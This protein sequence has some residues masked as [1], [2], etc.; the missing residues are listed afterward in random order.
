[1]NPKQKQSNKPKVKWFEYENKPVE[2][3]PCFKNVPFEE[4]VEAAF[5]KSV[6]IIGPIGRY[7]VEGEYTVLYTPEYG[8]LWYGDLTRDDIEYRIPALVKIIGVDDMFSIR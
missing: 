5:A 1:M 7:D 8:K 6:E 4:D 2:Y 3:N